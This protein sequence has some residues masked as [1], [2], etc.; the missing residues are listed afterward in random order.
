MF[1]MVT[2]RY[3]RPPSGCRAPPRGWRHARLH[4][5]C[6]IKLCSLAIYKIIWNLGTLKSYIH[7]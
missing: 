3:A 2:Q 7:I 6:N 1:M 5:D 4:W